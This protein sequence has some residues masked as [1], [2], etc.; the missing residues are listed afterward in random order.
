MRVFTH[1]IALGVMTCLALLLLGCHQ[2]TGAAG[3]YHMGQLEA[4]L[5]ASPQTVMNASKAAIS[6]LHFAEVSS[7]QEGLDGQIVAK[8]ADDRKV[9][10]K[11]DGQSDRVTKVV[12]IVGVLG[13]ES[14]SRQVLDKIRSNL[15][16]L[17]R[18]TRAL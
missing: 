2:E 13:D 10:V 3:A 17:D 6:D 14:L 11:I 7:K 4:T 1:A 8:T 12:I 5:D 16:M 15:P 9:Q 18:T